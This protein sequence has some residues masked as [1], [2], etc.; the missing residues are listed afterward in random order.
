M[1]APAPAPVQIGET[2]SMVHAVDLAHQ[3]AQTTP[4]LSFGQDGVTIQQPVVRPPV[5]VYLIAR[6]SVYKLGE[7]LDGIC[8]GDRTPEGADPTSA[9]L[10]SGYHE[11]TAVGGA[12][13]HKVLH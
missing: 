12:K 5:T 8:G 3:K 11:D 2:N 7:R 1:A 9:V 4:Q 6:P 13:F 10:W